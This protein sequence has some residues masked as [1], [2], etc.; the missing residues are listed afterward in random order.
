[1]PARSATPA[2]PTL[3]P[4]SF[5]QL[6]LLLS[7]IHYSKTQLLSATPPTPTPPRALSPALPV[8]SAGYLNALHPLSPGHVSPTAASSLQLLKLQRPILQHSLLQAGGI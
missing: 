8:S 3:P 7:N 4:S 1:M 6:L 5:S 2:T